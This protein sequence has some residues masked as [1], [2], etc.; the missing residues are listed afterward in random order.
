MTAV[1]PSLPSRLQVQALE[2]MALVWRCDPPRHDISLEAISEALLSAAL[3]LTGAQQGRWAES[4]LRS[5]EARIAAVGGCLAPGLRSSGPDSLQAWRQET[6]DRLRSLLEP[7]VLAAAEAALGPLLQYHHPS[8]LRA[9]FALLRQE[10]APLLQE[11]PAPWL[12]TLLALVPKRQ[13]AVFQAWQISHAGVLPP[14]SLLQQLQAELQSQAG[15]VP[16]PTEATQPTTDL[17]VLERYDVTAD[18]L[19][20]RIVTDLLTSV[21]FPEHAMA[22]VISELM[23]DLDIPPPYPSRLEPEWL[24]TLSAKTRVDLME[25]WDDLRLRHWI[26]NNLLNRAT[27]YFHQSASD[28]DRYVYECIQVSNAEMAH[29]LIQLLAVSESNFGQLATRYSEGEERWTRGL[30]G[31]VQASALGP[32]L[33]TLLTRL[34]PGEIHPPCRLDGDLRIVRL[35]HHFPASLDQSLCKQLMWEIFEQDLDASVMHHLD[36]IEQSVGDLPALF[37]SFNLL[38]ADRTTPYKD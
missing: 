2:T 38:P 8:D 7:P 5:L 32:E 36:Q 23:K 3:L 34:K 6:H 35:L 10:L 11:H 28:F 17:A 27:E 4:E 22:D 31:P 15:L 16:V 20:R 25:S 9:C 26:E 37:Q 12:D 1:F 33:R 13:I 29:K 19:R 21:I 24:M 18:A 30:V 14:P